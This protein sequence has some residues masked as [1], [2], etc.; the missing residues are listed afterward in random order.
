MQLVAHGSGNLWKRRR[1]D[2]VACGGRPAVR[3]RIDLPA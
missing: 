2:A 1:G 3:L